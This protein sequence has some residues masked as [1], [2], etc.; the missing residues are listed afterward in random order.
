MYYS[1]FLFK[2]NT[3]TVL[4]PNYN[5]KR[6]NSCQ[7][8]EA[9][10]RKNNNNITFHENSHLSNQTNHPNRIQLVAF[11]WVLKNPN[12][13]GIISLCCCSISDTKQAK[14]KYRKKQT[15]HLQLYPN[16]PC[17]VCHSLLPPSTIV[18]GAV[19]YH[20]HHDSIKLWDKTHHSFN[21]NNNRKNRKY[22]KHANRTGLPASQQLNFAFR[23]TVR[24]R[25]DPPLASF[26]PAPIIRGSG[27]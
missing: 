15:P 19:H 11:N 27:S 4:Q 20:H 9:N 5:F 21:N 3:K 22:R 13:P 7:M 18:P 16:S 24:A 8:D 25:C 23:A 17:S 6:L 2:K 12:P 14:P 10:Q 26:S 1:A